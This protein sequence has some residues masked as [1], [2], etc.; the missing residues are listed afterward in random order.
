MRTSGTFHSVKEFHDFLV[1]PIKKRPRPDFVDRYRP[2]FPDD[3]EVVF[4]HADLSWENILV[5]PS[6]GNVTGIL[7]WEMAGFWP[8]W[9]EFR[10]ALYGGRSRKWWREILNDVMQQYL[11]ETT[12]DMDVEMF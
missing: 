11:T 2:S 5:D 8:E 7:D 6:S 12:G 10:K 3:A 9:W 4:A 1:T